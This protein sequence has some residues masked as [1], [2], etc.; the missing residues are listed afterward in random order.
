MALDSN[1]IKFVSVSK[2]VVSPGSPPREISQL[3]HTASSHLGPY[4]CTCL[5]SYI[6]PPGPSAKSQTQHRTMD[7]IWYFLKW[8]YGSICLIKRL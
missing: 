3:L 2:G 5:I 8:V 1:K 7:R 4:L 6:I